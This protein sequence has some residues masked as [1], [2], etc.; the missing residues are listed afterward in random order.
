MVRI[1]VRRSLEGAFRNVFL[2]CAH[3]SEK[4]YSTCGNDAFCCEAL[5]GA[6]TPSVPQLETVCRVTPNSDATS[7]W[8]I[9]CFFRNFISF[10]PSMRRPFAI[11]PSSTILADWKLALK[12]ISPAFRQIRL[13]RRRDGASET[14]R[15]QS[16]A[17][18]RA[19]G[20]PRH[21]LAIALPRET[22]PEAGITRDGQPRK[23]RKVCDDLAYKKSHPVENADSASPA[24]RADQIGAHHAALPKMRS[25]CTPPRARCPIAGCHRPPNAHRRRVGRRPSSQRPAY[26]T[27]SMR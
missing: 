2:R 21:D 1:P 27:L 17:P 18:K 20:A 11:V 23:S 7:C 10:S 13:A 26:S 15:T 12:Q 22:A 5:L 4:R 24:L 14:A 9:P 8:L 16:G 19:S 25:P 3:Q 6:Y